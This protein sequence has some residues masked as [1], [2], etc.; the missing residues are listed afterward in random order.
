LNLVFCKDAFAAGDFFLRELK[1]GGTR[2]AGCVT[3]APKT[4]EVAAQSGGKA[5]VLT[6]SLNLAGS[7]DILVVNKGFAQ[8]YTNLVAGLVA[9]LLERN[10]MVRDNTARTSTRSPKLLSGTGHKPKPS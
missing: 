9:G 8:Q 6:T 7:G 5:H 3:W 10:R 2:S 4:T 1:E